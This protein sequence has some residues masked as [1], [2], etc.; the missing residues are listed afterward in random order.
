MK[1]IAISQFCIFKTDYAK[2]KVN[3]TEMSALFYY[4]ELKE[5]QNIADVDKKHCA[6]VLF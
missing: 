4:I 5:S 3:Q 6:Q 2:E 1:T